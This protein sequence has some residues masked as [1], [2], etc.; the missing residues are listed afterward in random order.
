ML[1]PIPENTAP[2]PVVSPNTARTETEITARARKPPRF[3]CA[4]R[5]LRCDA[6]E[7]MDP[8]CVAWH[9]ESC[10]AVCPDC[11]GLCW[12]PDL[13]PCGCLC[14]VVEMYPPLI[15]RRLAAI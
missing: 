2:G 7:C 13:R 3:N 8:Q 10:W 6:R 1:H 4:G 11:D 14:G 15:T 5:C 12:L 9:E